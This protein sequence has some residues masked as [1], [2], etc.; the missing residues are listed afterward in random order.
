MKNPLSIE[1]F[2][3][4]CEKQPAGRGYDWTDDETCAVAQYA[5]A[6]GRR[7]DD[8]PLAWE[9]V[10]MNG[11]MDQTFGALAKRLREAAP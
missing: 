2:A 11:G 5:K 1:A 8:M 7:P 10:A 9:A 3:D 4:W 6:H